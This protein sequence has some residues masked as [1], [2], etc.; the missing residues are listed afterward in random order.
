MKIP[1]INTRIARP[2]YSGWMKEKIAAADDIRNSG[3]KQQVAMP[4]I[5]NTPKSLSLDG[6]IPE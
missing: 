5:A 6:F 1:A 3:S 2:A 4:V